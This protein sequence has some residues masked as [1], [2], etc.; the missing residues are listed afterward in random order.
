MLKFRF[1]CFIYI[2]LFLTQN[3]LVMIFKMSIFSKKLVPVS[4]YFIKFIN[5]II[6]F[7]GSDLDLEPDPAKRFRSG[8]TTLWTGMCKSIQIH[9]D[10]DFGRTFFFFA[11]DT[12]MV[13]KIRRLLHWSPSLSSAKTNHKKSEWSTFSELPCLARWSPSSPSLLKEAE[14]Q[15]L[16]H[17]NM[18]SEGTGTSNNLD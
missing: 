1:F 10:D 12:W 6:I 2:F 4:S 18:Q 15:F 13:C 16:Q 11:K 8:S 9:N 3:F 17:L 5:R 14:D 7:F